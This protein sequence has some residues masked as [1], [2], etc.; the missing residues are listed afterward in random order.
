MACAAVDFIDYYSVKLK[1][2]MHFIFEL[3]AS[4]SIFELDASISMGV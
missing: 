1:L 2:P 4:I 3:E